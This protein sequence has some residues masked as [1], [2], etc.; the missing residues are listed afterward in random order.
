MSFNLC[1]DFGFS[2]RILAHGI[3]KITGG[4]YNDHNRTEERNYCKVW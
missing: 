4:F 3:S 1:S 2:N